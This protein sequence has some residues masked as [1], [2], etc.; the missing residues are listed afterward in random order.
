ME[1]YFALTLSLSLLRWCSV[2]SVITGST[3]SVKTCRVCSGGKTL[4]HLP[5]CCNLESTH[6]HIVSPHVMPLQMTAMRS[7]PSCQSLWCSYVGFVP[8]TKRGKGGS[9]QWRNTLRSHWTRWSTC[10][11]PDQ[12]NRNT[13]YRVSYR[14]FGWGEGTILSNLEFFISSFRILEGEEGFPACV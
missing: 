5:C 11:Q 13:P 8:L 4:P 1:F 7:S 10:R 12:R 6:S 9:W 2:A 3:R 14:L